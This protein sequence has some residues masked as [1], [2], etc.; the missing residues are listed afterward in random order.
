MIKQ[1]LTATSDQ[2]VVLAM[3]KEHIKQIRARSTD[4]ISQLFLGYR[5]P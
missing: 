2:Q 5:G 4:D 3:C 1:T